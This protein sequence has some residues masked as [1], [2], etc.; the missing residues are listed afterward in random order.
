MIHDST[1]IGDASVSKLIK[2]MEVTISGIRKK[3]LDFLPLE[4]LIG[5]K[6]MEGLWQK[7]K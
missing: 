3:G 6:V 1:L 7:E 4:K 5:R 2:Q